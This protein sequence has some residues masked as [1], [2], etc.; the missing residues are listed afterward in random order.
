V[1]RLLL[2]AGVSAAAAIAAVFSDGAR[3][4]PAAP[5]SPAR[6]AVA[7][8]REPAAPS[9][10]SA[11]DIDRT[12]LSDSAP[13]PRDLFGPATPNRR[14]ARPSSAPALPGQ[15]ETPAPEV[16]YLGR[17][18]SDG[19]AQAMVQAEGDAKLL[20]VGESVARDWVVKAMTDEEL[21]LRGPDGRDLTI[22]RG[23]R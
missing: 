3:E 5:Q 1:S 10:G 22:A 6:E 8:H 21:T 14:A 11:L 12:A 16:T 2:L 17:M 18:V 9:A 15:P 19:V 23:G 4:Q 13:P 7:L 20:R